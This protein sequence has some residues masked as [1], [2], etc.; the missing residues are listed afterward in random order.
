MGFDVI[1]LM[2]GRVLDW[3]PNAIASKTTRFCGEM[4][5]NF[6]RI[7]N[8][9]CQKVPKQFIDHKAWKYQ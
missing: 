9:F 2:P 4:Q 8:R 3:L 7:R 1:Y 6:P 5:L